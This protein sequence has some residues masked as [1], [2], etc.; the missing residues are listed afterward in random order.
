MVALLVQQHWDRNDWLELPFVALGYGI[1]RG[2]GE[3]VVKVAK[4]A[5]ITVEP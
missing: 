1:L 2:G 3:V 5:N 4:Y